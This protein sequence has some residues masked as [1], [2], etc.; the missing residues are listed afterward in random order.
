MT[1]ASDCCTISI[2]NKLTEIRHVAEVIEN[3]SVEW[4]LLPKL[5]KQLNLAIEEVVSNIIFYAYSDKKEHVITLE[6]KNQ[7]KGI[8]IQVTDDGKSFNLL[9]SGCEVDINTSIEERKIG[10]LGIHILKT[11]V[12][13][14]KYER[15]GEWN[16]VQITKY[17]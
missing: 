5:S 15:R 11:L 13:E 12:D 10:G 4:K 16:V 8:C 14:I 2:P 9:E 17:Y 7:E 6:I 1:Q 3:L